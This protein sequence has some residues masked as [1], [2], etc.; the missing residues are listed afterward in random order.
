MTLV[1]MVD[2]FLQY[3]CPKQGLLKN[4]CLVESLLELEDFTLVKNT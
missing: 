3:S 1:Y 4:T 2:K